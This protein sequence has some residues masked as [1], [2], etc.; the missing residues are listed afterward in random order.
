MV[1]Q[2]SLRK[3]HG[4][5]GNSWPLLT[6]VVGFESPTPPHFLSLFSEG[7]Y[8]VELTGAKTMET[9]INLDTDI[10]IKRNLQ[11]S[12]DIESIRRQEEQFWDSHYLNESPQQE[13]IRET[14]ESV[15]ES[16]CVLTEFA[17]DEHQ[18]EVAELVRAAINTRD[19]AQIGKMFRELVNKGLD[20]YLLLN[21]NIAAE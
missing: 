18:G 17:I 7:V 21:Y 8:M 2:L 11:D 16:V 13:A 15:R 3:K 14:L 19:D 4:T 1:N 20:S 6:V 12:K 9:P 5:T 10:D